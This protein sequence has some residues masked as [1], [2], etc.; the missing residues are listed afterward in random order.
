MRRPAIYELKNETTAVQLLQL[1]GGLLPEAD[2]AI[3]TIDRVNA[4][5]ERITVDVN[6]TTSASSVNLQAGDTLR[7]PTIRPVVTD[8]VVLSGHLHRP[9]R[10]QFVPGMRLTDLLPSLDELQEN[11]DQRYVLVRRELPDLLL[12]S[13]A[14]EAPQLR[15]PFLR[16]TPPGMQ[17]SLI[18]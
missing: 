1:G 17:V 12:M 7:V 6:I 2:P 10:Y 18:Q 16:L 5:R 15:Q 9:G 8:S 11:A 3:A 4:Q 13:T 14:E